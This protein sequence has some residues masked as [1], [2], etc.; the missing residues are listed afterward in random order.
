MS[1][2]PIKKLGST[3]AEGFPLSEGRSPEAVSYKETVSLEKD[4][5]SFTFYAHKIYKIS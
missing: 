1:E 3:T 2:L 5:R 4:L